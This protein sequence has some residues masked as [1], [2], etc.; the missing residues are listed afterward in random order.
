MDSE[1][2]WKRVKISRKSVNLLFHGCTISYIRKVCRGRCCESST[3]P[4]GISV[5]IIAG[6]QKRIQKL[7]GRIV[8]GLL[9][10]RYGEKKCPFK[11]E[12]HLCRLHSKRS[13]PFGCIA[14]PFIL[15]ANDTLIVRNRYKLLRCYRGG[16]EPLPA[17]EAFRASL[18]LIFGVA[19]GKNVVRRLKE[20]EEDIYAWMPIQSYNALSSNAAARKEMR[21]C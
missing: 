5:A 16:A 6:E 12:E 7:G 13:K 2:N 11:S 3:S 9:M 15:N 4:T 17:Y 21:S 20:S 10:P 8:N 1:L 18:G 19:N 14:S